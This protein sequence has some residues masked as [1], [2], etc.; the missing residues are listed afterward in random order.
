M[1]APAVA[2]VAGASSAKGEEGEGTAV[3]LGDERGAL[4]SDKDLAVDD[5]EAGDPPSAPRIPKAR[6]PHPGLV[7]DQP[8]AGVATGL[9]AERRRDQQVAVRHPGDFYGLADLLVGDEAVAVE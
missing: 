9:E 2:S 7:A 5:A 3:A 1:S 8:H 4:A 6:V